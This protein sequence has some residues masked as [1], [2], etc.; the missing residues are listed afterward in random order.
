M[1]VIIVLHDVVRNSSS[2]ADRY[3]RKFAKDT[4]N[5]NH[6]QDRFLVVKV[7]YHSRSNRLQPI[8]NKAM[9]KMKFAIIVIKHIK[10]IKHKYI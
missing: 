6:I 4:L 3:Q 8:Y 9:S 1:D 2:V 5:G 7:V 10:F